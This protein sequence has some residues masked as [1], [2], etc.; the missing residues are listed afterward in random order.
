VQAR[1]LKTNRNS[2]RDAIRECVVKGS[3]VPRAGGAKGRKGGA[4]EGAEASKGG[5]ENWEREIAVMVGAV[6]GALGR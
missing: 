3:I 2:I 1:T 6:V 4:G 5:E